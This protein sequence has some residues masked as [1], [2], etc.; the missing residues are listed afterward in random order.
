[1]FEGNI[2][3]CDDELVGRLTI[4]LNDDRAIF[5]FCLLEQWAKTPIWQDAKACVGKLNKSMTGTLSD[6]V[7]SEAGRQFL[8][9][10]LVQLT[11]SQLHDLFEVPGLDYVVAEVPEQALL[12]DGHPALPG[13]IGIAD[14][15][16]PRLRTTIAGR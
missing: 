8:A 10:L 12:A 2:R 5:A 3:Y 4:S 1:M 16:E 14:A 6:P 9:D 7:I 11:D 15:L 13:S